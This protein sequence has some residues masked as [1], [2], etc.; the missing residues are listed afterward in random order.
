MAARRARAHRQLDRRLWRPRGLGGGLGARHGRCAHRA[1]GIVAMDHP[2]TAGGQQGARRLG[3][4]SPHRQY[5]DGA[6]CRATVPPDRAGALSRLGR[7][8]AGPVCRRLCPL[9][10]SDLFRPVADDGAEPGRGDR[11]DQPRR[12]RAADRPRGRS[13]AGRAVEQRAV[14]PDAGRYRKVEQRPQQHRGMAGER[15]GGAGRAPGPRCRLSRRD[16]RPQRHPRDAGSRGDARRA[17]VRT[18]RGLCRL[19]D[20]GAGQP[21]HLRL[22]QR[23]RRAAARGDGDD[24][25]DADLARAD[26]LFRRHAARL[27]RHHLR[28]AGVPARADRTDAANHADPRRYAAAVLGDAA[29]S[30]HADGPAARADRLA[31]LALFAGRDAARGRLGGVLPLRPAQRQPRAGRRARL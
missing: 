21:V 6:G 27:W 28:D 1:A 19:Y 30:R 7:A 17:V 12:C 4:L 20:P 9:A 23:T 13:G 26:A 22:A 15:I 8:A 24:A 3:L 25:A 10:A 31:R 16:R 18:E 11:L 29:R 2:G 14:R 5:P